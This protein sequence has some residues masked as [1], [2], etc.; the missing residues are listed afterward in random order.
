MTLKR[1]TGARMDALLQDADW[2]QVGTNGM[3]EQQP[4]AAVATEEAA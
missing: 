3:D 1:D 4:L 2:A